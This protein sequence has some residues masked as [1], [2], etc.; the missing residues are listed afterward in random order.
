M[1]SILATQLLSACAS[2]DDCRTPTEREMRMGEVH[3]VLASCSKS[4]SAPVAAA[5]ET[6]GT[7]P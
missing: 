2:G 5:P 6:K 3:G 7:K 1:A 4:P